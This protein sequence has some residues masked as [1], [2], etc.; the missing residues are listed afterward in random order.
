VDFGDSEEQVH[1]SVSKGVLLFPILK[2]HDIL[3][4]R[5]V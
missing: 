4:T 1:F 2:E 3:R 5:L